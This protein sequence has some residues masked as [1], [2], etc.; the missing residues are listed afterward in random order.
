M[1]R[2]EVVRQMVNC[3]PTTT[4][5]AETLAEAH[6]LFD[7]ALTAGAIFAEIYDAENQST[8]RVEYPRMTWV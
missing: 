3:G 4:K 6:A 8:I 7:A 2:Y 1:D 5:F